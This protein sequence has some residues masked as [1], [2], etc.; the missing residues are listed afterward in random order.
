MPPELRANFLIESAR[1]ERMFGAENSAIALLY[2][3]QRV[4]QVHGLNRTLFEVDE[5]LSTVGP[6]VVQTESG[7]IRIPNIPDPTAHVVDGLRRM[8]A[9]VVG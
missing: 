2:E 4:A 9:T 3:A 5:M 8:L 1:G 7:R 6:K